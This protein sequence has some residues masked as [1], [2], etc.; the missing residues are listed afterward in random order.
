MNLN[1]LKK[2]PLGKSIAGLLQSKSSLKLK[3]L[4]T[5]K[6]H[7]AAISFV[8]INKSYNLII[9][10]DIE[11]IVCIWDIKENKLLKKIYSHHYFDPKIFQ[12]VIFSGKSDENLLLNKFILKKLE[13]K[14]IGVDRQ[15]IKQISICEENG[16][17][18]CISKDYLS[19]YSINGVILCSIHRKFNE[20][21]KIYPKFKFCLIT[22]VRNK[23]HL[24]NILNF[25]LIK[26]KGGSDDNY[27]II[28]HKTGIIS[29]WI[30][31]PNLKNVELLDKNRHNPSENIYTDLY[32]GKFE[33]EI[34]L[35]KLYV[36]YVLKMIH[37]TNNFNNKNYQIQFLKL[38]DDQKKLYSLHK[39][40][41]IY[42]LVIFIVINISYFN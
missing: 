25:L 26:A 6:S 24:L 19:V 4:K 41:E 14:K 35:F 3:V 38:N 40:G 17:F 2:I 8:E 42:S 32:S 30:L 9:S 27:I 28:G 18:A 5:F 11:G 23:N 34:N 29:F 33:R 31:K 39:N 22:T 15:K 20:E 37:L 12:N 7:L 16:D 21:D 13:Y 1:N 36:P 10:G